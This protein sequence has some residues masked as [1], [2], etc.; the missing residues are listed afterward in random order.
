MDLAICGGHVIDPSAEIDE[1]LD[2]LV[3]EGKIIDIARHINISQKVDVINASGCLVTPGLIDFHTH[4]FYR[5]GP[6]SINPDE[7]GPKSGVTTMV[8]AGSAGP[9]NFG[10]FYDNVI[11]KAKTRIK[12]FLHIAFTGLEG[13]AICSYQD[14]AIVGEL[15]D[16][17]RAMVRPAVEI[18]RAYPEVICGIKV[19]ASLEA[20]GA[21]GLVAIDLAKQVAEL[22]N[23]PVMVHIGTPPPTRDEIL[24][25]L[26][27]GDVLT[28]A[29]RGHPNGPY[30]FDG[31]VMNSMVKARARGV[32]FDVGHGKGS[33]AFSSGNKLVRDAS[34]LPD[35]ISTD[36]HASSSGLPADDLPTTMSKFLALGMKLVDVV[37]ATTATPAKSLG[38]SAILGSL[39]KGYTADIAIFKL[40]RC[41]MVFHDAFGETMEGKDVLTPVATIREGEVLWSA[42]S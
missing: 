25:R 10:C 19:R 5:G 16:I 9:G 14:L 31:S 29:Y 37:R 39:S 38:I 17:R 30:G 28:H 32:L 35:I 34:F 20:T 8:D 41:N 11:Q 23:L 36:V 33:F 26:R 27:P 15:E 18:A 1:V 6:W 42:P 21:F 40:K 22:V 24:Q 4:V 7:L 2:I 13:G 12:A 3:S